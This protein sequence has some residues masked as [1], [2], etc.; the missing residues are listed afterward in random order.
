MRGIRALRE[1]DGLDAHVVF[2]LQVQ[3]SNTKL[4]AVVS[5]GSTSP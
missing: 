3:H 5:G 2:S 1:A 4:E